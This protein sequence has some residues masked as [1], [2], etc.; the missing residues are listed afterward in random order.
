MRNHRPHPRAYVSTAVLASALTGACAAAPSTASLDLNGREQAS[1]AVLAT[2]TAL[3]ITATDFGF[4][5]RRIQVPAGRKVSLSFANKGVMAH[6]WVIQALDRHLTAKSGQTATQELTFDKPG[7]YDITCSIPFHTEWGMQGKL[8]VVADANAPVKAL[9]A[10][11]GSPLPAGVQRLPQP[12]VA[13]PIKRNAPAV[14]PIEIETREVQ[15]LIA[16]GVA[17]TYWTFGGTVPGPM[18]RVRQGDTVQLT[19]KN[20]IASKD[21]HS[22][23]FH[24][25]TGPGGGGKDTQIPPG[26]K[27]QISFKALNPGVYVYHCATPKVA[28]HI[29]NGMY[30]LMVVEPPEGL[31][32]VDREYYV[33]Q[34]DF[35]LKGDRASTGLREFSWEKLLLDEPDFVVMNGAAGAVSGDHAFKAKVGETA[36]IFFGVGGP[37]L[38]S[39]FHAIGEIFD[40]V[41]PEGASEVQ[42]NVQTTLVPAGGATMVEMKLEVPGTYPLVDHSLGRLEKGAAAMLMVE[43]APQPDVFKAGPREDGA[44]D[45]HGEEAA[46]S[47]HADQA[48]TGKT[49]DTH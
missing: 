21:T 6:D 20:A 36:R 31:P 26:G 14:V 40:K 37:N 35:Y 24:A 18:V 5:P 15:G 30:G 43:G 7:E 1:A 48:S 41:Y 3:T 23:D 4:E 17:T 44:G 46:G 29:A 13:P 49:A 10:P 34:G 32:A 28:A 33:M 25:A 16:D 45:G 19:L 8:V 27:A 42:R 39:S 47:G 38:T 11:S 2:A 22:I 9:D 12:A